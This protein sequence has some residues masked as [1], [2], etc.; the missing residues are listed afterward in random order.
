MS[1]SSLTRHECVFIIRDWYICALARVAFI[2]FLN[3]NVKINRQCIKMKTCYN[4]WTQPRSRTRTYARIHV[5]D[6]V[7]SDLLYSINSI[8]N[9]WN[10]F[11][12]VQN[13]YRQWKPTHWLHIQVQN[14]A[15]KFNAILS[16][17]NYELKVKLRSFLQEKTFSF[18][19]FFFKNS[20]DLCITA[21]SLWNK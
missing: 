14:I 8:L 5:H 11:F 4:R 16:D 6:H 19:F 21:V 20:K 9:E 1:S 10:R 12:S 17:L 7:P 3:F 13:C 15:R 2:V 18:C